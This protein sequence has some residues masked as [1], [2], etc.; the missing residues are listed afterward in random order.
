MDIQKITSS[1]TVV[2]LTTTCI[3]ALIIAALA[4]PWGTEEKTYIPVKHT[5]DSVTLK[6]GTKLN[7]RIIALPGTYSGI[8]LYSSANTFW[9]RGLNVTI[10]DQSGQIASGNFVK[11]TFLPAND[12]IMRLEIPTNHFTITKSTHLFVHIATIDQQ[13]LPLKTSSDN[14]ELYA[15][16]ELT[17]NET[18]TS[19]DL[20]LS[21]TKPAPLSF[22]A[23][24]GMIVSAV[25]LLGLALLSLLPRAKHRWLGAAILITVITPLALAGYWFSSAPL[26]ISDWDYYFSL[27]HVYRQTILEHGQ[28][29]FWNPFTCGGTAGWADPEFPLFTPT[30]L[31]ELIF[32]IPTGLRLA[33]FLSTAVGALGMLAL[34]KRL[35]LSPPAALLAGLAAFFGSVNL[36]EITEGHVN[37]F[38][39]MWIPWIFWAWLGAYRKRSGGWPLICGIFLA[40]T[41]YQ[42]GIYLLMYTALAFLILPFLVSRPRDAIIVT[43]QAGLWALGLTAVKLIPVL[44]WLQQFPDESFASSAL[45]LPWLTEIFFGRHLHGTYVIPRQNSGWHEYGAYL[46]YLVFALALIGSSKLKQSRVVRALVVAA[47]LATLLSSLGPYLKP[48]FDHLWFFPRSSISRVILYAVIPMALLAGIGLDSIAGAEWI[49]FCR[50]GV[51]GKRAKRAGD[52]RGKN[53][54]PRCLLLILLPGLVAIDLFSLSSQISEQAFILPEVYPAPVAAPPPIAFTANRY[55]TLGQGSRHTRSYAA[56]RAGYGTLTYCSVLGPSPAV[57]TIHDEIDNGILLLSDLSA[58][59]QLIHWSP[60][61]VTAAIT[62]PHQTRVILNTNYARGWTADGYII[63]QHDGRVGATMDNS[64]QITFRYRPPGLK[65]GLVI[66][67]FTMLAAGLRIIGHP[68]VIPHLPGQQRP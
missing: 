53:L 61:T 31:L 37:I 28:F 30:F 36:L 47:A 5:N 7:Q 62:T 63:K 60:N 4:A 55:D 54:I 9:G 27:H 22:G 18:K 14:Q 43:F 58:S 2:L 35:G 26:G 11:T 23:R 25:F 10:Q 6:P 15:S 67:L 20:A 29:P 59:Y 16:G 68:A 34:A 21:L 39:A 17:I 56:A 48:L 66:S 65:F 41:F 64:G 44:F 42:G 52:K 50:V 13:D 8:V 57:R 49:N 40:L 19:R 51:G 12:E 38:A 3:A 32:G 1:R 45:T 33:I 24:Q 46:G